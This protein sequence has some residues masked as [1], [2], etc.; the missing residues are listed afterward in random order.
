M[1]ISR[2]ALDDV[3]SLTAYTGLSGIFLIAGFIIMPMRQIERW[4]SKE[5]TPM[6][7]A[8]FHQS[9]DDARCL[10]WRNTFM[11]SAFYGDEHHR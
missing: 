10:R 2:I 3:L 7:G 9:S 8:Y 1:Q 6:Y 4:P 11:P 5:A